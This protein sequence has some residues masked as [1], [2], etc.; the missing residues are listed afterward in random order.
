MAHNLSFNVSAQA[1]VV[2]MGEDNEVQSWFQRTRLSPGAEW[3]GS[4]A[5]MMLILLSSSFLP[6]V[7]G[8]AS[9]F[10]GRGGHSLTV[11]HKAAAAPGLACGDH[12][13]MAEQ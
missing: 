10:G 6:A 2:S 4:R 8:M 11:R 3:V 7:P 9:A 13:S 12:M 1:W 5:L